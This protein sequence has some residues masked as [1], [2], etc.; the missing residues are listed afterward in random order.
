[1]HK[2]SYRCNMSGTC[3]KAQCCICILDKDN[4]EIMR[5]ADC[6]GIADGACL[7]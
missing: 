3:C 4:P 7:W 1:M 5:T 2:H 6:G